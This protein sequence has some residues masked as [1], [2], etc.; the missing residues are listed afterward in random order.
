MPGKLEL[1]IT[2][3]PLRTVVILGIIFLIIGVIIGRTTK[4]PLV[5][6]NK[7]LRESGYKYINPILL[8]NINPPQSYNENISLSKQ[9]A[10]YAKKNSNNNISVYFLNL[11]G[12]G[13]A[14]YNENESFS[15][16]SMLKVP[17]SVDALKYAEINPE[18]LTKRIYFDGSFDDN[19]AEY[20]K[21]IKSITPNQSYNIN[22]LI[23]YTIEYSDNNALKL[24]H[25]SIDASA[26][27]SLYKDLNIEIPQ[28]TIDFMS[29][30][31]Y[32][33]FLRVLYNSTYLNREMSEKILTLMTYPDFLK[34]IRSGVPAQIEVASKFGERQVFNKGG[35]LIKREL[36]DCG[37]V[38]T[39]NNNYILCVMTSGEDFDSL[40][41]N[42]KD[43]SEITYKSVSSGL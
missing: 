23:E 33:L 18:I 28:N 30:K 8:C 37:I 14:S 32:S 26:L 10:E 2:K 25:D 9:I 34:G 7:V 41:K 6:K 1:L 17:T 40:S 43:I 24:I 19:K 20:F 13:W 11:T 38:Y 29:V 5:I 35:D 27:E 3:K 4:A 15:P 21:P 36:H 22:D 42:I 31:T 39:P 16:A 12:G